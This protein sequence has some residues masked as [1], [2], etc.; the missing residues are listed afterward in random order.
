MAYDKS[1][2]DEC[3]KRLMRARLSLL[4]NHGFFGLMLSHMIFT[5]DEE[6]ETAAT[7]GERI[8]FGPE[9]MK[10]LS[11]S[12]LEFVLMHEIMHVALFHCYR[13]EDRDHTLFNVATDIVVNSNIMHSLGD[14]VK[15]ITLKKYGESMHKVPD[16]REGYLFTAEEVYDMI[17]S[18]LKG[19]K[20]QGGQ[21]S[22]N[23]KGSSKTGKGRAS[24][25]SNLG[26]KGKGAGG[27]GDDGDK[28]DGQIF[29]DD[30]S[31]W[32][33]FDPDKAEKL[34]DI[35]AKHLED[36]ANVISILEGSDQCGSMPMCAKRLLEEL[37]NVETDWKALLNDFV[38]EEICDYSFSP[39]DRRFSET[40]FF[41]PDYNEKDE[42]VKNILFMIDTSGS[43]S[44]AMISKAYSEVRGAIEQFGGKLEG[45]LGFFD[46]QVVKP[47]KFSTVEEFKIIRP[48][49]GGG[50]RFDII[51]DYAVEE[52]EE[53]PASIIIL[54]DGYA[55]FPKI[56][57]TEEIPVL[58]IINNKDVTP[59][60]GKIARI[61]ER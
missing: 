31:K 49:G 46:A 53:K 23:D 6:C 37:K 45:W 29:H 36:A 51:F 28:G 25:D 52:M 32:G 9:F 35:W 1:F 27:D 12:E 19:K 10:N 16:G 21:G 33:A 5:I 2:L 24:P 48:Y 59:P 3:G 61:S 56:E 7:D 26:G 13:D 44:D 4:V 47:Q 40:D 42:S 20:P 60:W 38:Q 54:T 30:H 34:H 8:Y 15:K 18:K 58:W 14:D 39:P 11:D 57:C 17:A 22:G 41:L 55:P 50:T 43:M